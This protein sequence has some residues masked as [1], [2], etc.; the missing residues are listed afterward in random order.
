[1]KI[2]YVNPRFSELVSE[3]SKLKS[4]DCSIVDLPTR[5]R[6]SGLALI[7]NAK[8]YLTTLKRLAKVDFTKC[9]VIHVQ[10]RYTL[11]FSIVKN[12]LATKR[13]VYTCHEGMWLADSRSFM[14]RPP[15]RNLEAISMLY[16][17]RIIAV[18]NALTSE[19]VSRFSSLKHKIHVIPNG[20]DTSHF[21]PQNP[22]HI[23]SVRQRLGNP[24][25][26]VLCVSRFAREKG[27]EVLVKAVWN[28]TREFGFHNLKCIMLL[29]Q[30]D[31]VYRNFIYNLVRRLELKSNIE[32]IEERLDKG[33]LRDLYCAADVFC[34]PSYYEAFGMVLIEA[35]ACGKP[36]VG[37]DQGGPKEIIKNEINGYTF[38]RGN[39]KELARVL[40]LLF[41]DQQKR[42]FVGHKARKIAEREYN[43]KRI[44]HRTVKVYEE[45]LN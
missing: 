28:L 8:T 39:D 13:T 25:Q 19:L 41:D 26:M 4:I 3:I 5:G 32:F 2:L 38:K 42:Y 14:R 6:Y 29:P 12:R 22:A 27:I 9:D 17:D 35:M 34:L 10:D 1:M 21:R 16:T 23:E 15:G 31:S 36:I 20:V 44:A 45:V 40:A 18:S 43:W 33:R 11:P 30:G 24:Q 37:P 7:R